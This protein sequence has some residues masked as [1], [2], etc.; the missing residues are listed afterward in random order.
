MEINIRP[1]E[2]RIVVEPLQEEEKTSGGIILP[3]Q[4]KEK[5]TKGKVVAT[6][7][8][9]ILK[10]GQRVELQVKN[11]DTVLFSQ[12]SG[13]DIKIGEKEYKILNESDVLGILD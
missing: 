3:E 5:P 4:S 13:T 10:S 8:G 12:Y 11:K 9:R 2:D 7:P 1:L 6:G